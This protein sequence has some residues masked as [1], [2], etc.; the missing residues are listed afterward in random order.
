MSSSWYDLADNFC[1]RRTSL[2]KVVNPYYESFA[3]RRYNYAKSVD[4]KSLRLVFLN[5]VG[6]EKVNKTLV[7]DGRFIWCK[8]LRYEG[9]SSDG[10]RV[11]SFT[12]S[13]GKKRFMVGE[14]NI[15]CLP[16]TVYVNN[17]AFMR[18]YDKIFTAF[19]SVFCYDKAL[20]VMMKN[21]KREWSSFE[22][23]ESHIIEKSPYK[24]GSL[25]S[26]R[27]GYFMPNRDKLSSKMESLVLSYCSENNCHNKQY[28][29]TDILSHRDKFLYKG[30]NT[31]LIANFFQWCETHS[32]AIH[33][34]GIILGRSRDTSSYAGRE[35]YRVNF[36]GTIYEQVHPVQ[37]EVI[38]E[39]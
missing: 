3:T 38:N 37:M 34:Y 25:V 39:V 35:L 17:N 22:E 4:R 31:E 30:N 33:P 29:L 23:F 27:M 20:K 36:G 6:K 24:T 32:G 8:G 15:L 11:L 13:K 9:N 2:G 14:N 1:A 12:I 26:A 21:D 28:E 5:G 16:S 18:N 10:T 7:R 19:S